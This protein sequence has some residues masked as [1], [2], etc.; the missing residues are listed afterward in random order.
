MAFS[1]ACRDDGETK[2]VVP[3]LGVTA[4]VSTP[5]PT[6]PPTS[7]R[8]P[9]TATRP[10]P[11]ATPRSNLAFSFG[12]GVDAGDR[13]II[14]N[15]VETS[16]KLLIAAGAIDAPC[17]VL[18]YD[19]LTGLSQAYTRTAG[20][21]AWRAADVVRRLLNGVAEAGYRNV[22]IYTNGSFWR[23]ANAVQRS[24]AVAHE[25][26]HVVQLE[27]LGERLADQ[28]FNTPADKVP[29]GGPFWLLEG[30]AELLSW[31]IIEE[32]RLGN[33]ESKL[34]EYRQHAA[35][36]SRTLAEMETYVGYIEGG[37][38]GVATSVLGV[39]ALLK[40]R[41]ASDLFRFW[42]LIRIGQPWQNAFVA[43]FGMPVADFYRV[44]A[45]GR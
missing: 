16:R 10:A 36:G 20:S 35:E 12:A 45:A 33:L 23:G 43:V 4:T 18:A 22:S 34:E 5:I 40:N 28:T 25:Y 6:P 7:T 13:A 30:S 37:Q 2:A 15:A 19:S 17:T 39:S 14:T 31:A 9:A 44:F 21:R 29:P 41:P 3:T 11:I 8:P 38:P 26:V 32:L 1:L 24:Q 27:L 42:A